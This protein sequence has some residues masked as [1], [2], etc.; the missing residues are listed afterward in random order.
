[1]W[2]HRVMKREKVD[3]DDDWY[4]IHEVYYKEN[5]EVDGYTSDG[6]AAGGY[7]LE[8]L[9]EE[10]TRMLE[11]T[12]KEILIYEDQ[13]YMETIDETTYKL[14]DVL[15]ILKNQ[16]GESFDDIMDVLDDV[17]DIRG[18]SKQHKLLSKQWNMLNH[19]YKLYDL[20]EGHSYYGHKEI[21]RIRK[22]MD[23]KVYYE[24]DKGFLNEQRVL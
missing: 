3:G 7:T 13:I 22:I 5:G 8:D 24:S 4:Q 11:A 20:T 19:M 17:L 12:E 1:M 15:N 10:L 6:I 16:K 21:T 23:D 2:N 18:K 9:R 14:P